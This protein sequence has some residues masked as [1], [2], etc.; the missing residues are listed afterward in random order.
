[1][2]GKKNQDL[3]TLIRPYTFV[4]QEG[5]AIK[6][7]FLDYSLRLLLGRPEFIHGSF[8]RRRKRRSK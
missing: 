7:N 4:L 2:K 1:M 6:N 3:N 8:S 5:K